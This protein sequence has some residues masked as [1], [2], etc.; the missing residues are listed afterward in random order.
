MISEILKEE[1]INISLRGNNKVEVMAELV[2]LVSNGFS[3]NSLSSK[4]SILKMILEREDKMS[5][6][7]GKGV[8]LPRYKGKEVDGILA[9]FGIKPEG[10]DFDAL[11]GN[12]VRFI[13]LVSAGEKEEEKYLEV[14]SRMARILNQEGFQDH[15]LQGKNPK[16]VFSLL[17]KEEEE[18]WK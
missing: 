15:L 3:A 8:A 12:P 2:N 6:G 17:K 11:D 5:T 4:D 1:R 9:S 18:L 16:E 13:F 10:I 7:I 14:L